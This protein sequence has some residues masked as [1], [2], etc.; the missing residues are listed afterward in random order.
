MD[1]SFLDEEGVEAQES[2]VKPTETTNVTQDT[3]NEDFNAWL[4]EDDNSNSLVNILENEESVIE[5]PV[6]SEDGI[7]V[8]ALKGMLNAVP[9]AIDN[10]AVFLYDI[11]PEPMANFFHDVDNQMEKAY[12]PSGLGVTEAGFF[13]DPK[14]LTDNMLELTGP[15]NTPGEISKDI[16]KVLLSFA[17]TKKFAPKDV[18]V[19]QR[20]GTNTLRMVPGDLLFWSK[21]D[22]H[23]SDILADNGIQNVVVDFLKSDPNDPVY[24]HNMKGAI[25]SGLVGTG[26]ESLGHSLVNMYRG[27]KSY[28]HSNASSKQVVEDLVDVISKEPIVPAKVPNNVKSTEYKPPH[29]QINYNKNPLYDA[30]YTENLLNSKTVRDAY[31]LNKVTQDITEAEAKAL[32]KKLGTKGTIELAEGTMKNV[33]DLSKVSVALRRELVDTDTRMKKAFELAKTTTG[34]SQQKALGSYLLELENFR[35]L[36]VNVKGVQTE[37]ARTL[38]S[39]NIYAFDDAKLRAVMDFATDHPQRFDEIMGDFFSAGKFSAEDTA[40]ILDT[41]TEIEQK[42]DALSKAAVT[43][44]KDSKG[45]KAMRVLLENMYNGILSNPI[46]H[47]INFIGNASATASRLIEHTTASVIGHTRQGISKVTGRMPKGGNDFIKINELSALKQGYMSGAWDTIT[48]VKRALHKLPQGADSFEEALQK[49][50]ITPTGKLDEDHTTRYLS[51][52]YLELEGKAGKGADALG[53]INRLSLNA[54]GIGDDLFK[55]M[56]YNSHV[57]Y[58]A[59]REAN[60]KTFKTDKARKEFIENFVNVMDSQVVVKNGGNVSPSMLSRI[61]KTDATGRFYDEAMSQAK[62]VT[63]QD[64]LGQAGKD[65]VKWKKDAFGGAGNVIMPFVKTPTNLIKWL[66]TRTPGLNF[67]SKRSRDMWKAGGRQRDIVAAQL[68]LGSSLYALAWNMA[69]EGKLTGTAPQGH[70]AAWNSAGVL[71][72][73]YINEK[74]E[75]IQYNRADPIASF[76]NITAT[77][78]QF[79]K[80]MERKGVT[81]DQEFIERFDDVVFEVISTFSENTLSKTYTTGVTEF[82]RAFDDPSP[83]K[84]RKYAQQKLLMFAPYSGMARYINEDNTNNRKLAITNMEKL[85]DLYGFRDDL[86]DQPDVYGK[87][88][89]K[90]ETFSGVQKR[91][92]SNSPIRQELMALGIRL[93]RMSPNITYNGIPLELNTKDL[94]KMRRLLD[95]RYNIEEELNKFIKSP[96]YQNTKLEGIDWSKEGTKRHLLNG[97]LQ[98][99]HKEALEYFLENNKELLNKYVNAHYERIGITQENRPSYIRQ[100]LEKATPDKKS[101]ELEEFLKE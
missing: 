8:G 100:W 47:K 97:E 37:V 94:A 2:T 74:G 49:G 81:E 43:R 54:L 22:K 59:V 41:I 88:A 93:P 39:F 78:N 96:T 17:L 64:E 58:M 16:S 79:W 80:E 25:E 40:K 84:W 73:S 56:T 92:I 82:L 14:Y 85:M 13:T 35:R 87:V 53:L 36:A 72:S 27:L 68:T 24:L 55:R 6:E 7:I 21:E 19:L 9:E 62:A 90:P 83:D 10:S 29:T 76:F 95:T 65:F 32:Q 5:N 46:T 33:E 45:V 60:K 42:G 71:E 89:P 34:T 77:L 44:L 3:S 99:Y 4:Y 48:N 28:L 70:R 86:P 12:G 66:I 98:K 31:N 63:F 51:G 61:S 50:F 15:L 30:S 52:K 91:K 57:H 20:I 75:T 67:A 69:D 101:V 18:G 1:L 38:S 23:I 26:L 11:M